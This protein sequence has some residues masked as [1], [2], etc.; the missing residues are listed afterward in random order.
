MSHT[1]KIFLKVIHARIYKKAEKNMSQEHL[2]SVMNLEL[3]KLYLAYKY[4][5]NDA[6]ISTKKYICALS[7]S[8]KHLRK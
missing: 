2:G 8:R 7:I 1:L 6:V 4:L 3:E 5:F